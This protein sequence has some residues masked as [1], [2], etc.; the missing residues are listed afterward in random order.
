MIFNLKSCFSVRQFCICTLVIYS[1]AT[2]AAEP[3]TP[4]AGSILR[5][6]Q[7]AT[8]PTPSS[9]GTGLELQKDATDKSTSSLPFLVKTIQISGNKLFSTTELHNLVADMEGKNLT[10]DQ[11]SKLAARITQY[12]RQHDYP[13]AQA[14]VPVQTLQSG[15]VCIEV[16]EARYGNVKLTNQSQ[17]ADSLVTS[18]LIPLQTGQAIG[19]TAL[20]QALLLLSDIP[21]IKSNAALKPGEAVGTSDILVNTGATPF[22]TGNINVNDYGN[23]YT[24]RPRAGAT[25]NLINPLHQGDILTVNGL[26]SGEGMN[27]GRIAYEFLVNGRGTRLGG[28][29]VY[30]HYALDGALASLNAHGEAQIGSV[31]AKHPI[32]RSRALNLYAQAQYDRIE[33]QDHQILTR[34]DRSLDNGILS[35]SG[36][37]RDGLLLGAV[38]TWNISWSIG[39]VG[40]DNEAASTDDFNSARTQGRYTKWNTNLSRLQNLSQSDTLYVSFGGQ[41]ALDNLDS[42]RK[43]VIG[44]PYTVR[45]YDLGA[46]SGDTGYIG[47]AELRHNLDFSRFGQWQAVA[48]VDSAHVQVDHNHSWSLGSNG[49]TLS[50]AGAG[51]NW[52]GPNKSMLNQLSARTYI[53]T[54]VGPVPLLVGKTDSVRAWMEINLGF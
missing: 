24:G 2:D 15:V 52:Q 14:F 13:L 35:L 10:L 1:F 21:G 32:I 54:P 49:A 40:F 23:R 51:L 31:W 7:P 27:Y 22:V 41:W 46:V 33:L 26:T 17:V 50:G 4:D 43:M 38:N 29:Y 11:L 9:T 5:Q 45:G 20:D 19:Q 48:F 53:A 28:S 8:P 25:V 47:T 12:Y 39:Q 30:M 6:I 37:L 16:I 34:R 42:S 3:I 36:D 18:T 44:G